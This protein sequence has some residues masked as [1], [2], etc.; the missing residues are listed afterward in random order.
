[1]TNRVTISLL[2]FYAGIGNISIVKEIVHRPKNGLSEGQKAT[3]LT[4][5]KTPASGPELAKKISKAVENDKTSAPGKNTLLSLPAT[6]TTHI[7]SYL[8]PQELAKAAPAHSY[9]ATAEQKAIFQQFLDKNR[10][11]YEELEYYRRA[12]HLKT[13]PQ[14]FHISDKAINKPDASLTIENSPIGAEELETIINCFPDLTEIRL[15]LCPNITDAAIQF[16]ARERP[17]LK[18]IWVDNCLGLMDAAIYL[19]LFP[20]LQKLSY[21]NAGVT[22]HHENLPEVLP[23]L[24]VLDLQIILGG[25]KEVIQRL[26]KCDQMEEVNLSN[27]AIPYETWSGHW[28]KLKRVTLPNSATNEEIVQIIQDHPDII[29]RNTELT[30]Q[31]SMSV[32]DQLEVIKHFPYLINIKSSSKNPLSLPLLAKNCPHLKSYLG[33]NI[34]IEQAAISFAKYCPLFMQ[35]SEVLR[36]RSELRYQARTMLGRAYQESLNRAADAEDEFQIFLQFQSII[37]SEFKKLSEF[38]RLGI[39]KS[40]SNADCDVFDSKKSIF[41]SAFKNHVFL[42]DEMS[43]RMPEG[44][45]NRIFN[46]ISKVSRK[47][48][49]D[50]SKITSLKEFYVSLANMSHISKLDFSNFGE[51]NDDLLLKVVRLKPRLKSIS[52]ACTKVTDASVEALAQNFPSL[53]EITFCYTHHVTEKSLAAIAKNCPK[54]TTLTANGIKCSFDA[55]MIVANGC[56]DLSDFDLDEDVWDTFTTE[57]ALTLAKCNYR[58]LLN[59]I[60]QSGFID[61]VKL[62]TLELRTPAKS[63]LALYYHQLLRNDDISEINALKNYFLNKEFSS[64]PENTRLLFSQ[65][66]VRFCDAVSPILSG[67]VPPLPPRAQQFIGLRELE[68]DQDIMLDIT[69]QENISSDDIIKILKSSPTIQYLHLEG[70]ENVT[71]K[72]LDQVV[73]Y[74]PKLIRINVNDCVQISDRG[75]AKLRKGLPSLQALSAKNC[76]KVTVLLQSDEKKDEKGNL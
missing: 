69:D 18:S 53:K 45:I 24:M 37:E 13:V 4:I 60:T 23:P 14:L 29:I 61:R 48:P 15:I 71:D 44:A 5:L 3:V 50:L 52:L 6:I 9:F 11:T 16:L 58:F 65:N 56:P 72:V 41:A 49:T 59:V 22:L 46:S 68:A 74:C 20:C 43:L 38:D 31:D 30:I 36:Y 55:L 33:V 12:L 63:K 64:L 32:E 57:N 27:Y 1:M 17:K 66:F 25:P 75:I 19:R 70:C 28:P 67:K 42:C 8:T 21:R 51:L 2:Q 76:P 62:F 10:F 39:L 54:I 7:L 73:R 47:P 26:L 40:I 34:N 35:P